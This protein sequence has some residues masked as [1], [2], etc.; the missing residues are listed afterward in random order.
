MSATPK[1]TAGAPPSAARWTSGESAWLNASRAQGNPPNGVRPRSASWATQSRATTSG[2]TRGAPAGTARAA[3]GRRPSRP[4]RC[5]ATPAPPGRAT[6]SCPRRSPD[7][8][9]TGTKKARP[10]PGRAAAPA[11]PGRRGSRG[12]AGRRRRGR[13]ATGCGRGTRA[14]AP[15]RRRARG[16]GG[17][18]PAQAMSPRRRGRARVPLVPALRRPDADPGLLSTEHASP[19]VGRPHPCGHVTGKVVPRIWK[20]TAAARASH[21]GTPD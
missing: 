17:S 18:A 14:T 10:A 3:A 1:V 6:A 21:P 19:S 4:A 2:R 12:R 5:R 9:S 16:S 15:G 8:E 11:G 20:H 7:H 13:G